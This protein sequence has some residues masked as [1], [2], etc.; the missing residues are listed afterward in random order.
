MPV[1][2]DESLN[3]SGIMENEMNTDNVVDSLDL[4][5]GAKMFNNNEADN[6]KN[7]QLLDLLQNLEEAKI[8]NNNEAE[9][10]L[11]VIEAPERTIKHPLKSAW[12]LW[13]FNKD[14]NK[15]WE[16][17]QRPIITVTTVED[18]WS[19]YNRIEVASRLPPGSDYSFFKE[20]IFPDWEDPRNQKGGRWI[21]QNLNMDF[22]DT[23]WLE[24]IFFMIGQAA[25]EDAD[26]ITGAAV[27][28]RMKPTKNKLAVWMTNAS[29]PDSVV[30]I[31][32][33]LKA[34]LGLKSPSSLRFNI[35][36]DEKVN[37]NPK[38]SGPYF[39]KSFFL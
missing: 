8:T 31:G 10:K 34:K 33:M 15:T 21:L 26:Q 24:I 38:R 23:Y 30:R 17:N 13:L 4:T 22:L 28:I 19:L 25:G 7:D 2:A 32:K 12:T 37:N 16:E 6:M 35:H 3:H 9:D 29:N 36:K 20:G 1:V 39:K 5:E 14:K 11:R 18:F 27:N